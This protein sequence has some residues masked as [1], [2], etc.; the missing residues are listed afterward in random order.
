M[1]VLAISCLLC[2]VWC[3][4]T[5][6]EERLRLKVFKH[7]PCTKGT[8]YEKIRFPN[9]NEAP[10]QEDPDNPGYYS[11][12]GGIVRV[13]K[14]INGNVQIYLEVKYGTNAPV[15]ECRRADEN[16][17][18]GVGS[19]VY[20]DICKGMKAL[21]KSSV[22]F[23]IAG[24]KPDCQ[25]GLSAGN[26]TD[27]TLS[28]A[29]PTKSEFLKSQKIDPSFWDRYGASGHMIFLTLYIFDTEVNSLSKSELS[30]EATPRNKNVCGCHKLVGSVYEA[31]SSP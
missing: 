6:G 25:K 19:C 8:P 31:G 5:K 2:A 18:G 22:E 26:Y 14:Q 30:A 21:G 17:C 27:I 12:E 3:G 28:F 1:K 4:S 29:M 16:N 20:C 11:V 10:L 7:Q 9:N 24:K 13:L 23:S 15:E